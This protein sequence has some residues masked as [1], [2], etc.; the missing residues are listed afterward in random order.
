MV[1][2]LFYASS[3]CVLLK[4]KISFCASLLY[5]IYSAFAFLTRYEGIELI[6]L[7]SIFALLLYLKNKKSIHFFVLKTALFVLVNIL[8]IISFSIIMRIPFLLY[9]NQINKL[10][11]FVK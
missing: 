8:T 9:S 10:C 2:L 1:Y 7:W 3:V 4:R 11:Q 5:G 6:V